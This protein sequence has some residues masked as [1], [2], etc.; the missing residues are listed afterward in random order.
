MGMDFEPIPVAAEWRKE[1]NDFFREEKK[2]APPQNGK[3]RQKR[4]P[5]TRVLLFRGI[6]AVS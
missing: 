2:K 5:P 3:A 6:W 1:Y 4:W